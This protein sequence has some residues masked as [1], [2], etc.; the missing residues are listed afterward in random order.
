[1][2][3]QAPTERDQAVAR[4]RGV[5]QGKRYDSVFGVYRRDIM[6]KSC[7]HL[8]FWGSD[9][10]FV[11]EMSLHNKIRMIPEMLFLRRCHPSQAGALPFKDKAGW[12]V[13]KGR[14]KATSPQLMALRA[15][16]DVIARAPINAYDRFRCRMIVLRQA[17]RLNK[18]TSSSYLGVGS[19]LSSLLS[20]RSESA[21]APTVGDRK[22]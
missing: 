21:T 13:A 5:I 10:T 18:W 15:Y 11:A 6:A 7:L 2:G 3:R 17:F 20:W 9:K 16:N 4:F 22:G 1:V 8:P 12:L 14:A 19:L